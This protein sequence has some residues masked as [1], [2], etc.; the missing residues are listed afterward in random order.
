M[1]QLALSYP[2]GLVREIVTPTKFIDEEKGNMGY[3]QGSS[4]FEYIYASDLSRNIHR[5]TK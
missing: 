1:A 3:I 4:Y 5:T 2:R